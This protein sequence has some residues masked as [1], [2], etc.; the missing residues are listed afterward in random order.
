M[1]CGVIELNYPRKETWSENNVK[2][3][4]K[5]QNGRRNQEYVLPLVNGLITCEFSND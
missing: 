1:I 4:G 5:N 2:E 3:G